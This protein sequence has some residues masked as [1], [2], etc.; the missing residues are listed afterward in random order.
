MNVICEHSEQVHSRGHRRRVVAAVLAA[1]GAVTLVL[2]GCA[3]SHQP[4]RDGIVRVVVGFYPLQFVA[5]QVGGDRVRVANLAQPGAEPHDLE[6]SPRQVADVADADLVV[7][8][9][10]FQPAMDQAAQQEAGGRSLDIA[11]VV[12]LRSADVVPRTP[13]EPA[14]DDEAAGGAAD[15]HLWL[16]PTRLSR[17]VDAV[18]ARLV[19]VNP[20]SATAY[21][22]RAAALRAE[23]T[24]LDQEYQRG[25][26]GCARHE[27][28][29]SHAAFGYLAERY[30]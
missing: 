23:L 6:L 28:V 4:S 22:Q 24:S 7:Y 16:D 21:H 11:K 9:G 13:G 5:E 14:V 18:A 27:I 26:R 2:S 20:A 17:V 19:A 29:V 12:P 3:G 1:A 8:L 30:G 25:L 10:G 15:P